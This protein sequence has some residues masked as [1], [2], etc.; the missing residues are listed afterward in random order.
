MSA[1]LRKKIKKKK[2]T[3]VHRWL[4]EVF[5]VKSLEKYI[6]INFSGIHTCYRRSYVS[7]RLGDLS[8]ATQQEMV[9][10]R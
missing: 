7:E 3:S 8:K 6:R 4:P 2:E 10:L 1:I 5:K 9:E